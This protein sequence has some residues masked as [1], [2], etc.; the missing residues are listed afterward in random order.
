MIHSLTVFKEVSLFLQSSG[1]NRFTYPPRVL[2]CFLAGLLICTRQLVFLTDVKR[3]WWL[4]R[5][6]RHTTWVTNHRTRGHGVGTLPP[7]QKRGSSTGVWAEPFNGS[8]R[9]HYSFPTS[10]QCHSE[11]DSRLMGACSA[12]WPLGTTCPRPFKSE[13]GRSSWSCWCIQGAGSKQA[14]RMLQGVLHQGKAGPGLKTEEGGNFQ[15]SFQVTPPRHSQKTR[16]LVDLQLLTSTPPKQI[17]Q[18]STQEVE[19]RLSRQ[20]HCYNVALSLD[21][22]SKVLLHHRDQSAS[23][24]F[25]VAT[26]PGDES[27]RTDLRESSWSL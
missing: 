26:I 1:E 13:D 2:S 21:I 27:L 7:R 15:I 18:F 16:V 10:G 3:S 23:P 19:Q 9:H 22:K 8:R 14:F 12:W 6:L 17:S 25:L 4:W 5:G 24:S 11:Q 20:S